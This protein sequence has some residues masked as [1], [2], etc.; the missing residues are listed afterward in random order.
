M[1]TLES[2]PTTAPAVTRQRLYRMMRVYKET[3]LLR[4]GV[5]TG[6]FD[7][8]A[9]GP[10]D[11]ADVAARL[12]GAERGVRLLL[13]ALAALELVTTTGDGRY[14]LDAGARELLV[15]AAPTYYGGM[16][17]VVASAEEWDALR[18][19]DAAVLAGGSV[20]DVDAETPGYAYWETFAQSVGPV[21]VPTAH[22]LGDLLEPWAAGREGL[23]ILDL[24]CGHGIY[25]FTLATRWAD[26]R[27]TGVDW[28]NVTAITARHA[29]EQGLADRF[30]PV[31]GDMFTTPVEGE[32]DLVLVTNVLHHFSE[33]R[34]TELL[35]R[36][37]ADLAP[38]GRIG[39]VGFVASDVPARD[40]EPY[41]F[42]ILM[43]VWTSAGEVH[44]EA[45]HRRMCA[46]AGLEIEA[47]RQVPGLPFHVL[48][49]R[50]AG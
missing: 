45:A 14:D 49:A 28:A 22:L 34:A 42:S 4:A 17:D 44:S 31:P 16:V 32:Q 12:G 41:L 5:R 15:R 3:A 20:R 23:R 26:A 48:T 43:L 6:V 2:T 13:D 46:A 9:E 8:L 40:P 21:T 18:D 39:V 35:R 29:A 11:V 27:V 50:R 30:T 25:G 7:A 47:T 19:L 33:E 24:A 38:G 36:A 1:T 10:A 37:A